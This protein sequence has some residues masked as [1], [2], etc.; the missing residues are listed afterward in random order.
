MPIIDCSSTEYLIREG[1][2]CAGYLEGG[3][4]ACSA[5]SGGP[6]VCDGV[7]AGIVSWGNGC[8]APLNP[9]VYTDVAYYQSWIS[10]QLTNYNT[11]LPQFGPEPPTEPGTDA[12]TEAV[13]EPA[14]KPNAT[15]RLRLSLF[16][17]SVLLTTNL[18][19]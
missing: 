15:A 12:A 18:I 8:G 2:L 5:D 14:T 19:S 6:L 17:L 11:S 7:Q 9:G 13:T 16:L 3:R 10:E 4:D 1:M